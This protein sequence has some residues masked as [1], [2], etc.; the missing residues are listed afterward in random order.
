MFRRF[1]FAL[2]AVA[3]LTLAAGG[4]RALAQ[5]KAGSAKTHDHLAWMAAKLKLDDRQRE[6]LQKIHADFDAK[7]DP[8]ENQLW[9]LHHE[10]REA[11]ERVLNV[12]QRGKAHEAMKGLIDQHLQKAAA[13]LNLT[14]EQKTKIN[15]I[16]DEYESKFH[17]VAASKEQ[18]EKSMKQFRELRHQMIGAIR[19]ELN[20]EQ[21]AKLPAIIREEYRFWRNVDTRRELCKELGEKVGVNT[22]QKEQFKKI[23]DEYDP[24]MQPLRAQLKQ[25]RQ[26]E[27]T[28]ID[29]VLTE[30]QRAKWKDLRKGQVNADNPE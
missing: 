21:R 23:R 30:D 9:S 12:D 22:Q 1:R 24:K 29:K 20:E 6:E 14:D 18:G 27:H 16:R 3:G 19:N 17:E 5:E 13:P 11:L 25:F 10:E 26:D 8:V 4:G 15:K 28:A 7:A 2:L